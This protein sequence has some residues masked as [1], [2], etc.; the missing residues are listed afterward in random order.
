[1]P[2]DD[3]QITVREATVADLTAIVHHRRS[4]FR[5]MGTEGVVLDEITRNSAPLIDRGLREGWYH[6]WLA[7]AGEEVA[8]G[9][10]VMVYDWPAGPLDPQQA[11]RAYSLNVFTEP[12]FRRLGLAR[13]LTETAIE[14]A[15]RA[16]FKVLWLHASEF[17]RPIYEK[18][19]FEQ[20]NEMKLRL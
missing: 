4:M 3:V 11:K 18:L 19:G 6:G 1:M 15:R 8:A 14:W 12:K 7:V 17:G 9:A 5:D 13:N 2:P 20:T 16:G 10:G